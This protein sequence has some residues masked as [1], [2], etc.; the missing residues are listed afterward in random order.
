MDLTLEQ[1]QELAQFPAPLR[2]LVEAELAAGNRI[3]EIGHS[4]PAPP[5][6][7][8]VKLSKKISTRPRASGEGLNSYERNSSVYCGEFTDARRFYFVLEP[9]N[10]PPPEPDMEVIRARNQAAPDALAQLAQRPA[11]PSCSPCLTG[12]RRGATRK[13]EIAEPEGRRPKPRGMAF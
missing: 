8:Y 12:G 13:P 3:A 2:A 5:S 10:P 9:P 11:G 4:H 6:G 7:A 1:Q